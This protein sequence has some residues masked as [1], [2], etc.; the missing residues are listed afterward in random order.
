MG[1]ICKPN[2]YGHFSHQEV[3][4]KTSLAEQG[5]YC[6]RKVK[7][8]NGHTS[9]FSIH[10]T[11]DQRKRSL[12]VVQD[13]CFLTLDFVFYCYYWRFNLNNMKYDP[14]RAL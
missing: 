7:N 14:K 5:K 13:L 4:W 3:K 9:L 2:L 10:H 11:N 1:G 8:T 6:P 12:E